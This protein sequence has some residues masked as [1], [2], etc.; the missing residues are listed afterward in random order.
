MPSG[1][2]KASLTKPAWSTH[3]RIDDET[4]AAVYHGLG[5]E[6]QD[7]WAVNSANTVA[8]EVFVSDT[9]NL[10][11]AHVVIERDAAQVELTGGIVSLPA[12]A[13]VADALVT[14]LAQVV[15]CGS[16]TDR[17]R[18]DYILGAVEELKFIVREI[19]GVELPT[20]APADQF[21]ALAL[22]EHGRSIHSMC[23]QCDAPRKAVAR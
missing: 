7:R 15:V 13:E 12:A 17:E 19:A 16:D 22:C 18:I 11:D 14:M 8:V 20:G 21:R 10:H 9:I 1:Q 3:S 4:P 2:S 6:V 5:Y 23:P